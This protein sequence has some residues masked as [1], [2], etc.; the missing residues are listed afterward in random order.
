MNNP[1]SWDILVTRIVLSVLVQILGDSKK[2][3][4]IYE[5]DEDL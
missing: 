1:D 2:G 5:L 3:M 4:S